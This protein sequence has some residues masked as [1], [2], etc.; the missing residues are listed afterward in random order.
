MIISYIFLKFK[1]YNWIPQIYND[2]KNLPE[3][4]PNELKRHIT[5]KHSLRPNEVST[6]LQ[7]YKNLFNPLVHIVSFHILCKG[8]YVN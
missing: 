4:M 5:E 6:K 2:S 3:E 7:Y 1:I 8:N